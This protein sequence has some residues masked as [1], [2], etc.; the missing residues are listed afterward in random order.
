MEDEAEAVTGSVGNAAYTLPSIEERMKW[1]GEEMVRQTIPGVVPDRCGDVID[2]VH[3]ALGDKHMARVVALSEPDT[4]TQSLGVLKPNG[5]IEVLSSELFDEYRQRPKVYTGTA[6]ATRIESFIAHVNRFKD[7]QSALFA[8]DDM[9]APSLRAVLDYN[10]D[11]NDHNIPDYGPRFGYHNTH[12]DFPL[13]DEWKQWKGK[14]G[15]KMGLVD[16]AEFIEDRFIDV[17]QVTDVTALNGDI[18]KLVGTIGASSL[19]SPSALIE[20]SRGLKVH[21]KDE[22]TN[23]VNVASG[24]GEVQFKTEH[25]DKYGNKLSIPSL[26]VL[27]IPVFARGDVYRIAARLRYRVKEGALTFWYELWGIDRVFELAFTDVC[28]LAQEQTGLPL[29]F[30][31]PE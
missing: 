11:R 14:N 13:S 3:A 8:W 10:E 16:F 15:V 5:H 28:N 6:T 19:A 17:E 23:A 24:E 2:K 27:N 18:Q 9:N 4:G 12:F 31:T 1:L 22:V 30:G 25:T 7:S 29:F 20:L 26:F 21:T